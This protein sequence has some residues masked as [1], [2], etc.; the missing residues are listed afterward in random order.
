MNDVLQQLSVFISEQFKI[1]L[2]ISS[3][4]FAMLLSFIEGLIVYITYKKTFQGVIYVKSFN[5][6]LV[7]LSLI[8]TMII[9]AISSNFVLSFGMVGALSIIRFRTAI[10]DPLDTVFMFWSISIGLVN[11]GGFY[12]LGILG[13]IIIS[14]IIMLLMR[15]HKFKT[16]YLLIVRYEKIENE[17][18]IT[19]FIKEKFKRYKIRS[20]IHN[21]INEI[22]YEIRLSDENV[23]NEIKN[24]KGVISFSL[25]SYSGD[26]IETI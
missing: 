9:M 5:V 24:L 14:L 1:N 10:K 20:K 26:Y 8:T 17:K 7:I 13:T 19:N 3:I 25:I 22:T 6:S 23:I 21:D 4:F 2:G 18:E 16:P 15:I 12:L 11:G